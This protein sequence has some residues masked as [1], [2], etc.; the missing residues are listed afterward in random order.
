MKFYEPGAALEQDMGV[1][2]SKVKV[3]IEAHYQASFKNCQGSRWRTVP[4]ILVRPVGSRR[5]CWM[6]AR[7]QPI[8]R[9]FTSGLRGVLS[10]CWSGVCQVRLERRT[11]GTC[12]NSS[13]TVDIVQGGVM[14]F[15]D[16][17][18]DREQVLMTA[19]AQ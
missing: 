7:Q 16:V 6:C 2:V 1:S 12:K 5:G 17:S 13:C 3:S 14:G 15:K 10:C 4:S 19:V 11:K 18:T 9:N 8:R